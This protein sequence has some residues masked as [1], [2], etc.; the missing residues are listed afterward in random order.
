MLFSSYAFVF[1]FLPLVYLGYR[2]CL[3]A[4]S[5][6]AV[7]VF[8]TLA[9]LVFYA[10]WNPRY[11]PLILASVL[12]NYALGLWLARQRDRWRLVL[13]VG[14]NLVLLGYYKYAGFLAANVNALGLTAWR[15]D[16]IVLPLAISFFTFQQIA[17]LVDVQRGQE[18]EP[19]P[20]RYALFV[21]FFPQLIAGPIVHHRQVRPQFASL[22]GWQAN[23][24]KLALGVTAFSVGLFKK[25]VL[26]DSL[27]P[28]ADAG[29]AAA[30]HGVSLG[31]IEAWACVL[32]YSFQLF[33]DFSGYSDMA[34]GLG[35]MFGISLPV[36]FFSPYRADSIIEFWRRWHIT[37]SHFLRDYLYKP[38]GGNRLGAT[39][40]YGNLLLT[41]LLGGLWHGAAWTFVL[42]GALHGIYLLINHAWRASLGRRFAVP[43]AL[44]WA[45]TFIA[46][47][48][49]WVVFRADS[50]ATARSMSWAMLGGHGLS[51]PS[52][53][54]ASILAILP[55]VRFEGVFDAHVLAQPLTVCALL[56]GAAAWCLALPNVAQVLRLDMAEP[57]LAPQPASSRALAWRP[58]LR[59]AVGTGVLALVA[60]VYLARVQSFLYYQF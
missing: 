14:A 18:A 36:N 40:R 25:V 7:T 9:S 32:A 37:L 5:L 56:L 21:L 42:W 46:V 29:F 57:G 30:A 28:Y 44:G 10:G 19:N 43:R 11:V 20:W 6:R 39:R 26:A 33:L 54:S 48:F 27:A 17:Y 55:G 58:T 4:G 15:F 13:A 31:M 3:R 50:M 23:S 2:L 22:A 12:T 47:V 16:D 24:E 8:M 51:L 1:V 49:A 45:L 34:I 41:M 52:S 59:W 53:W 35:L 38:L 60:I